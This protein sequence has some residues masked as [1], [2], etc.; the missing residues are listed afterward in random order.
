MTAV[1]NPETGVVSGAGATPGALVTATLPDGG[2]ATGTANPD[3]SYSLSPLSPKP[4]NGE[5]IAVSAPHA[6][7]PAETASATAPDNTQM[8]ASIT[9]E[10]VVSGTGA[11]PGAVVTASLP[12][13]ATATGTANADGTY[14]LSAFNP[15]PVK[16]ETVNVSAPHA[17]GAPEATTVTAYNEAPVAD[18]STGSGT[19][20]STTVTGDVSGNVTHKDGTETY[21]LDDPLTATGAHGSLLMNADGSWTYTRTANLNAIQAAVEETFTYRVTDSAGNHTTATLKITG[22]SQ[23]AANIAGDLR[24]KSPGQML[25]SQLER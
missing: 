13:G 1:Y 10:G 17:A 15:A 24:L 8:T 20:D 3:G 22:S 7:G 9:P 18:L 4:V 14:T 6:T 21:A 23:R 11:T 5:N 16:G 25:L 2:T 12:S 19:E